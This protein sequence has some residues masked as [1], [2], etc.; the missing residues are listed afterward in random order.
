MEASNVDEPVTFLSYESSEFQA[1][2][3]GEEHLVFSYLESIKIYIDLLKKQSQCQWH[4][5][6]MSPLSFRQ[7][8]LARNTLCFHI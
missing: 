7:T 6:L 3:L 1:G 4:S 5:S 2:Y 8:T